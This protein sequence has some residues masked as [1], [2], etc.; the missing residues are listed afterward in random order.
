[1]KL[2]TIF[3]ILVLLNN[4]SFDNKSGIWKNE[5]RSPNLS[6]DS[7]QEFK[8]LS[9]SNKVFDQTINIKQDFRFKVTDP[10]NNDKWEDIY[11]DQTNNFRN[12][13]YRDLNTI[14]FR[15]K[16]LTK[17][18]TSNYLLYQN[19]KLIMNDIK[20][21]IIVFSM[22]EKKIISKFNF[23][24]KKYKKIDKILNI[25]AD[26]N[27][28]YVSD[29]IGYLYAFNFEKDKLIWAKNYK[30]PFRSNLKLSKGKLIAANQNNSLY[31]FNKYDGEIVRLIPTEETVIK[32]KFSNNLSLNDN[33]L[34][35]LNTYGSIY[36]INTNSM[37]II[38]FL[39]LNQSFDI[40]PSNLFFSNQIINND[41]KIVIS[42][43]QFTYIIDLKSGAILHKK[44]F[45]SQVK[46]IILDDYLFLI[47]KKN[48]LISVNLN[49]GK[50]IFSYNIDDKIAKFLNTKKKKV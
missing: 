13:Q 46:P 44:N 49:N 35:F 4:C 21:N 50:I 31:F 28:I 20:G 24:K 47:T 10:I 17:Y 40:N 37:K 48:Y 29:N 23:Y 3:I 38:W 15:S 30:I 18:N 22:S 43:N 32:N 11:F 2:L 27:S 19:D 33:L 9:L 26:E 6:K 25:I 36:A 39:N 12:F 1:M 34:F 14:S 45:S 7:N 5:N 41:N 8:T 16:K 42:T